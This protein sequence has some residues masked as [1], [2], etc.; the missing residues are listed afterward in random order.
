VSLPRIPGYE[1]LDRLGGGAAGMVYLARDTALDR[2]VAIKVYRFTEDSEAGQGQ[3][4]FAREARLF[5]QLRHEAILP[6]L[7]AD[8]DH[9]PPYLVFQV[10]RGGDL[11]REIGRGPAT[12]RRV[13]EVGIRL[14]Q[15]LGCLHEAGVLHRD[16]KPGNVLLDAEGHPYL[17]DLG[18]G[19]SKGDSSLTATNHVVG[20]PL[21]MAPEIYEQGQY[22]PRTD[23][24]ALGATLLE[25]TLGELPAKPGQLYP[26]TERVAHAPLRGILRRALRELPRNRTASA[27]V[28]EEDLQKLL[29]ALNEGGPAK[30][31]SRD[32]DVTLAPDDATRTALQ[33]SP[34]VVA[35]AVAAATAPPDPGPPPA[36]RS[37]VALAALALLVGSEALVHLGTMVWRGL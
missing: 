36:P 16:V 9:H 20:S 27:A 34:E 17:G 30:V 4:R 33:D 15:G 5:G 31:V 37:H 24:F 23:V 1:I 14:A 10:L 32:E 26:L 35:A 25:M 8:L 2:E 22:S 3:E 6:V 13:A 19:M 12:T 21:Y 7:A 18:L 29:T 11:R 28:L